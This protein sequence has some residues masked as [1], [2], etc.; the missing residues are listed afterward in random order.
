MLQSEALNLWIMEE[1]MLIDDMKFKFLDKRSPSSY[2][3]TIANNMQVLFLFFL[4]IS[5]S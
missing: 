4:I 1:M 5:Y 2:A 3:T